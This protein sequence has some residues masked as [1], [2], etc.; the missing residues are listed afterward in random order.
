MALPAGGLASGTTGDVNDMFTLG[1]QCRRSPS[2]FGI[3]LVSTVLTTSG[4]CDT[5]GR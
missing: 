3:K 1:Y 4:P 2:I 5:I